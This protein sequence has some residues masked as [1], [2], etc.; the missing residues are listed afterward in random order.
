LK[1][2]SIN[3]INI[4]NKPKVK[5]LSQLWFFNMSHT[6]F[7]KSSSLSN[8]KELRYLS[9]KK[10]QGVIE[11]TRPQSVPY[12]PVIVDP[13]FR[14]AELKKVDDYN[15]S[16]EFVKC[17]CYREVLDEY[18]SHPCCLFCNAYPIYPDFSD[19]EE[20]VEPHDP[21]FCS[22]KGGKRCGSSWK[23]ARTTSN[24]P[25]INRRGQKESLKRKKKNRTLS[26]WYAL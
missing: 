24:Y 17:I 1:T 16:L 7:F 13:H 9:N 3:K 18:D 26:E 25:K 15:K 10:R 4:I 8:R 19:E 14:V 5:V 11:E 22:S 21:F 6:T 2:P 23:R 12:S 20:G